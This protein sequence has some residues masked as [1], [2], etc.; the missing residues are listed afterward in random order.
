MA[1]AQSG[2]TVRVHYTG[3]LAD[4]TVF[5]SSQGRDPLEFTL[6]TGQVIPGFEAAVTGMEPGQEQSVTIPAEQAYGPPKPELMIEVPRTQFPPDI[7][8]EVGQRLQMN[9]G[10][11]TAVVTV[12]QVGDGAVK[13]DA[14]HPLAGKDLTFDSS[15]SRSA[16]GRA[17]QVSRHDNLSSVGRPPRLSPEDSRG[18]RPTAT[19][20]RPIPARLPSRHRREEFAERHPLEAAAVGTLEVRQRC[21]NGPIDQQDSPGSSSIGGPSSSFSGQMSRYSTQLVAAVR[22]PRRASGAGGPGS[23]RRRA[24]PRRSGSRRPSSRK[25]QPPAGPGVPSASR[26]PWRRR[27]RSASTVKTVRSST[28]Q[29]EQPCRHRSRSACRHASAAD[30]SSTSAYRTSR[31]ASGSVVS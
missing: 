24:G 4:G 28:Q 13:L 31:A 15:S 10:Q 16:E 8:P 12:Q 18:G 14:N 6:G 5:D 27:I 22:G 26:S 19:I 1:Q 23:G 25:A 17:G 11:Q 20:G 7:D 9:N 2:D 30:R 29:A 3:K 21:S